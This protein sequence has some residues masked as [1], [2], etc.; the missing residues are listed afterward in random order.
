MKSG[1]IIKIHPLKPTHIENNLLIPIW[2]FKIKYENIVI[3]NGLT[4][5]RLIASARLILLI[6]IK[7]NK[8]PIKKNKPLNT[9]TK[10]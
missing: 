2:F 7:N 10:G 5:K 6:E 3:K 1:L 8:K 4:K 9:A